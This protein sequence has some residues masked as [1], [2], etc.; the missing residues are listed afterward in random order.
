MLDFNEFG[1]DDGDS[2]DCN[3]QGEV[4]YVLEVTVKQMNTKVS[5]VRGEEVLIADA[6]EHEDRSQSIGMTGHGERL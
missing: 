5:T 1:G 3:F 4:G 2:N 6:L